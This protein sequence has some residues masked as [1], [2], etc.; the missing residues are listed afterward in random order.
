MEVQGCPPLA[1][2]A[3]HDSEIRCT[4]TPILK[5]ACRKRLRLIK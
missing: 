3:R 4:V 5:A 2:S 1:E